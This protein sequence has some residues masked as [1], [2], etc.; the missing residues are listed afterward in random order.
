[1]RDAEDV[2]AV[3]PAHREEAV[4]RGQELGADRVG[5]ALGHDEPGM[6]MRE[7][8]D[9]LHLL[10]SERRPTGN[11][12]AGRYQSVHRREVRQLLQNPSRHTRRRGDASRRGG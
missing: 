2:G 5:V 10:V 7:V 9:V 6:C 12:D 1:M 3:A 11:E 4:R 8:D